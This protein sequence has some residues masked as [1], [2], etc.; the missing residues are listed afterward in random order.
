LLYLST[1]APM[2]PGCRR[3]NDA[4]SDRVPDRWTDLALA[5]FAPDDSILNAVVIGANLSP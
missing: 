4:F 2:A 3:D 1:N 5:R